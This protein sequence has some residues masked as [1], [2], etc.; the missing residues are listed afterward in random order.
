[1]RAPRSAAASRTAFPARATR[2]AGRGHGKDGRTLATRRDARMMGLGRNPFPVKGEERR[3]RFLM[4]EGWVAERDRA[5][6]WPR[7]VSPAPAGAI[8]KTTR[9]Y[10]MV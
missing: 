5:R 7:S 8:G 9:V 10:P 4:E 1:M 3:R 2:L 6:P